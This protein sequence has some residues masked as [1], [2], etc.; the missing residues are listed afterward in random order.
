MGL[1]WEHDFTEED[2][3]KLRKAIR[4]AESHTSGEI[5]VYFEKS[6]ENEPV[7]QRAQEAF[8]ALN[9]HDTKDRNGV[10]FYVAFED[11]VFAVV[12]DVGIHEKVHQEFWDSTKDI[13]A[14]HFA[15]E[16][17]VEGLSKAILEVGTQLKSFFPWEDDDKN[18]LS[19]EPVFKNETP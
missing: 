5:R 1:L 3:D 11:R 4:S 8:I 15:S 12:G 19:D 9:M 14:A 7:L 13:L 2:K 18:E 17:Y 10:L 6:T 16:A